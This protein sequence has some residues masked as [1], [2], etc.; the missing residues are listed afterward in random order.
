VSPLPILAI[1][2]AGDRATIVFKKPQEL[3]LIQCSA[4]GRVRVEL[5][6]PF[7]PGTGAIEGLARGPVAL[8]NVAALT[9]S[10]AKDED[11][12]KAIA[13]AKRIWAQAGIELRLTG[14]ITHPKDPGGLAVIEA[15]SVKTFSDDLGSERK[16]LFGLN[17][18]AVAIDIYYVKEITGAPAAEG[19]GTNDLNPPMAAFRGDIDVESGHPTIAD[20]I[21][22]HELGHIL[23]DLPPTVNAGGQ[24]HRLF[25]RNPDGSLEDGPDAPVGNVMHET[26]IAG[27][28]ELTGDQCRRAIDPSRRQSPPLTPFVTFVE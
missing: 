28:E 27:N 6:A 20:V 10:G 5:G 11:I 25:T 13:G 26:A 22:A 24:D 9:T 3:E 12:L 2:E 1:P 16:K 14:K 7:A 8:L 15:L 17:S 19:F 21:L 23:I 4:G 18:S